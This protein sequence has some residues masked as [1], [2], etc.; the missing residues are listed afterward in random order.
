MIGNAVYNFDAACDLRL[1]RAMH[2]ICS[3]RSQQTTQSLP[4]PQ[5]TLLQHSN[6]SLTLAELALIGRGVQLPNVEHDPLPDGELLSNGS[7]V[8]PRGYANLANRRLSLLLATCGEKAQRGHLVM[9][10]ES[11]PTCVRWQPRPLG[12]AQLSSCDC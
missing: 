5:A 7:Q 6:C 2:C 9:L 8:S 10:H 11:L 1:S 4:S 12:L 3:S